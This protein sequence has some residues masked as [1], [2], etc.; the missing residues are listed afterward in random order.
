MKASTA[1]RAKVRTE[2]KVFQAKRIAQNVYTFLRWLDL[3]MKKTSDHERG[4]RIALAANDLERATDM[5]VRFDL[6]LDWGP[7]NKMKDGK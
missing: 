6:G 2:I 4:K 3:E 7:M 5:F 1:N